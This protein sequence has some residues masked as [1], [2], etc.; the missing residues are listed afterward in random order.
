MLF[1]VVSAHSGCTEQP[2]YVIRNLN[3][4]RS[5]Y[6][7]TVYPNNL[8][9]IQKG[10]SAVPSGLFNKNAAGRISP[11]GNFT[12]FD[13]SIEY[14]FALAP[15]PDTNPGKVAIY[16]A[17]LVEFTS[18]CPE[19]ASSLVYLRTGVIDKKTNKVDLSKPTTTLAQVAFW[20]FDDQGAVLNYHAW[21]P[22]LQTWTEVG[23]NVDFD[24]VVIQKAVPVQLCPQIMQNCKGDNQQYSSVATCVAALELKPFGSFDEAWGDNI[25]CREIH[26][27]LTKVRPEVHCP[28]VGP[29]GGSPPD[30]WKCVD[31][32][33]SVDY[34]DDSQLFGMP[35]GSTF[36]CGAPL[37]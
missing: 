35:L 24:N 13:D 10:A 34:F 7:I 23:N 31:I 11:V 19:V 12:G 17:Q 3:T 26:V 5:I 14:F 29:K 4:I 36:T 9:I 2:D 27:L 33:Y 32:D 28:H 6:N 22:N 15:T 1:T 30:N 37:L 20:K 16:E 8:P 18:G 25:V 21:I